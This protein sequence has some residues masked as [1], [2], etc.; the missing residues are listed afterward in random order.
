MFER[1][2]S[3][4]AVMPQE[5][6]A[7]VVSGVIAIA[8]A[9]LI[10]PLAFGPLRLNDSFWIDQVWLD[11]FARQV[12]EGVIYPRWL[13]LSHGGLGSPVFYYYPPLAFYVGM[14]FVLLGLNIH[15][16][17]IATFFAGYLLSGAAMYLWL[18]RQT[19]NPLL[20]TLVFMAAPYHTFN[21]YN[22]GALAEFM[23]TALL[24]FVVVG[25]WRL[26]RVGGGGFALAAVA[27]GAMIATHLPLALLASLFL[28]APLA[29]I[30]VYREPQAACSIALALVAGVGLAAVYWLPAIWLEPYRDTAKLS[31]D[32]ILQPGK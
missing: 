23:A 13:P 12:G 10:M 1:S 6:R 30:R 5:S 19:V 16:A 2:I 7:W 8:A 17:L 31:S 24:P 21:V 28:I 4:D 18:R 11:Q 27:Y 26:K 20:G 15:A 9:I 25:V 32:T 3:T 29:V 14:P 22:R